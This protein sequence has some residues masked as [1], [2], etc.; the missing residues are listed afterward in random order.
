MIL[1]SAAS[2]S[3]PGILVDAPTFVYKSLDYLKD[4]YSEYFITSKNHKKEED[5]VQMN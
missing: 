3:Q 4:Q 2:V 5:D 1:L